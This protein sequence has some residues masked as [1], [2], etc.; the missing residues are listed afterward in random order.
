MTRDTPAPQELS[1]DTGA[2]PPAER[3]DRFRAIFGIGAEVMATGPAPRAT[4]QGWR[5]DRAILYE[6]WLND[7]G[8]SRTTTALPRYGMKHWTVTLVL[9]GRHALDWGNGLRTLEPGELMFAY[10][11]TPGRSDS[12]Q[13]HLAT[14]SIADD[15]LKEAV[16]PLDGLHGL[17]VPA[18]HGQLYAGFVRSLLASVSSV[19]RRALPATTTALGLIIKAALDAHKGTRTAVTADRAVLRLAQVRATIDAH[20][21]DPAF[22]ID[23]AVA[24]TGLSR[25]TL[26]RLL[27]HEGGLGAYIQRQRLEQIRRA[28]SDRGERRPFGELAL[29]AGFRDEGQAS[30]A[31]TARFGDR[32]GAYRSAVVRTEPDGQ[33]RA[34][35][36]DLR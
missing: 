9:E 31:F 16:G 24:A 21:S 18:R 5:L 19:D 10:T 17:V 6:R 27:R 35:Q 7:I 15:R 14:L 30:R 32:P 8:L 11:H 28:L 33:F 26:Y 4:F 2:F 22:G 23:A 20:L 36:Q 13:A 25:A 12:R 29:A 34:W 3:L 1:F